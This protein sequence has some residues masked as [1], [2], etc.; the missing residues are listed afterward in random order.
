M[1]MI[2]SVTSRDHSAAAHLYRSMR[3]SAHTKQSRMA[4]SRL[5]IPAC[6]FNF[7][8]TDNTHSIRPSISHLH[9]QNRHFKTRISQLDQGKS[10]TRFLHLQTVELLMNS[11]NH[12]LMVMGEQPTLTTP[13]CTRIRVCIRRRASECERQDG[14]TKTLP[15][16]QTGCWVQ[17]LPE[18]V[19]PAVI[20]EHESPTWLPPVVGMVSPKNP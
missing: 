9:T 2:R 6:K 1:F 18:P 5:S 13:F 12:P 17:A 7:I 11:R 14:L 8:H 4:P 3:V 20:G 19:P 15:A 16:Q 10:M